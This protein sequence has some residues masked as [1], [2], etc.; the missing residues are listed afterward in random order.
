MV[1]VDVVSGDVGQKAFEEFRVMAGRGSQAP[2]KRQ[3]RLHGSGE[4]EVAWTPFVPG[5]P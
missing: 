5:R 4:T 2:L 3:Q 1:A